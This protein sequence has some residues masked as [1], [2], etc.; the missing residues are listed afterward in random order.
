[1]VDYRSISQEKSLTDSFVLNFKL[2]Y[3]LSLAIIGK[4][5]IISVGCM[6]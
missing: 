1:M 2:D 6:K 5:N 4:T 3:V